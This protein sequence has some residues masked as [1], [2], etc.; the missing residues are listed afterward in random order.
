LTF[1][2]QTFTECRPSEALVIQRLCS[3]DV[4]LHPKLI[5][6]L[7]QILRVTGRRMWSIRCVSIKRDQTLV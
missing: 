2:G 3:L 1:K 6:I 4:K 5:H 7:N